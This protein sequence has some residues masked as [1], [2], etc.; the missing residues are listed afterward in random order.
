MSSEMSFNCLKQYYS[1]KTKDGRCRPVLIGFSGNS[2]AVRLS[3]ALTRIKPQFFDGVDIPREHLWKER[4]PTGRYVP[5]E[6]PRVKLK[7][8]QAPAPRILPANAKTL[9]EALTQVL[10]PGESI[11][12]IGEVRD[13]HGIIFFR[14]PLGE[15][16][17]HI[18]LWDL[19]HCD[20]WT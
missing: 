11:R 14:G 8:E 1:V 15:A 7:F 6:D 16:S 20:R 13:K 10:G 19:N 2:C 5:T 3:D 17:G 18:S 12:S 9:A 4:I